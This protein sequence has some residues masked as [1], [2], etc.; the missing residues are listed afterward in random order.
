[1]AARP[2]RRERPVA[3]RGAADRGVEVRVAGQGADQPVQP[4]ERDLP[5]AQAAD[6]LDPQP[7][8]GE[9]TQEGRRRDV[10]EVPGRVEGEPP[11]AEQPRLQAR[12]VGQRHDE[13]AAGAQQGP[14]VVERGARPAQVLEAVPEDDRSVG[15]RVI[16]EVAVLALE[17]AGLT[18]AA[19]Q[20]VDEPALA[21]AHVEDRTG[22]GKAVDPARRQRAAASQQ[23]VPGAAEAPRRGP[24]GGG[25]GG[26]ELGV[27]R[28]RIGR[29]GS[30]GRAAQAAGARTPPRRAAA[31][32]TRRRRVDGGAPWRR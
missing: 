25:V 1:V 3:G 29:H 21:G 24:V 7:E 13:Q 23:G 8:V 9:A 15:A 28:P 5:A 17:A 26:V 11:L 30:A 16:E 4:P 22:R 10:D 18:T 14:R 32:R 6:G 27:A 12:R 31:P 20:G 19:A 2:A